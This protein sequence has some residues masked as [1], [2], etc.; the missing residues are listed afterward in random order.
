MH[1]NHPFETSIQIYHNCAPEIRYGYQ[2]HVND[3]MNMH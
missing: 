3:Q 1:Y 2:L